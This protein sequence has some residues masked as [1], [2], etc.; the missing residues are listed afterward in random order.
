[1]APNQ[2]SQAH[3]ECAHWCS[4]A[5]CLDSRALLGAVRDGDLPDSCALPGNY[6]STGTKRLQDEWE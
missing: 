3:I 5:A 6:R 2:T 4:G 1:M